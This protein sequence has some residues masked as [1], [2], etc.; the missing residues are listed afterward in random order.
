[1]SIVT[2]EENLEKALKNIED[3]ARNADVYCCVYSGITGVFR[4]IQMCKAANYF[5]L[6]MYSDGQPNYYRNWV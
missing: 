5:N 3:S 6:D 2:L 4:A 1:M